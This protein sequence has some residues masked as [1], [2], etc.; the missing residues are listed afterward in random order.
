VFV[1]WEIESN[2]TQE[3]IGPVKKNGVPHSLALR[4]AVEDIAQVGRQI[5][6]LTQSAVDKSD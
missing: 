5:D 2:A 3:F 4:I 6:A 1:D